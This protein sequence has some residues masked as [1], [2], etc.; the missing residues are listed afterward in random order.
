LRR[1]GLRLSDLDGI[2]VALLDGYARAQAKV[3]LLDEHFE[4]EGL[5]D[6][7]GEP[8]PATRFYLGCL[9]SARH[10]LTKLEAHLRARRGDP[11]AD[12]HAYLEANYAEDDGEA[13]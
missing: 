10:A 11:V 12:L 6:D 4:R 9:N 3:I 8:Q 2:G 1:N 13:A 5:L 7:S